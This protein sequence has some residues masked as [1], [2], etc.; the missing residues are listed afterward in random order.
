MAIIT[1]LLKTDFFGSKKEIRIE[2]HFSD[3]NKH[4]Q[5]QL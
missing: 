4:G 2:R 1:I 3:T 5:Y